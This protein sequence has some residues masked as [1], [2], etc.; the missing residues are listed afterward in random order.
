MPRLFTAIPL[1]PPLAE[2]LAD[3]AMPLAGARWIEP[4]DM[5]I[6]LRFV[7]DIDNPTADAFHAALASIDEPAFTL[8]LSGFGAFGGREPRSLWAGVAESPWLDAL[9]RANDRA[10]RIAGLK[11]EKHAFK[12][13]VTLARLKGTRPESVARVLEQLGAFASE[14]FAVES[15]AL[16]SSRPK[17]GG[18][19][20]VVEDT[21]QLRGADYASHWTG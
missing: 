13:H 3:F 4:E 18:G 8:A 5:H 17:I 11:P 9:A 20:Y 10:A 2:Q 14:P 16:L 19:P 1:P 15:F 7:G 6:T 12:A 21:F